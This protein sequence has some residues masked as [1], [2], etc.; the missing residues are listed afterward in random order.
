MYVLGEDRRYHR[1]ARDN[2][3]HL[4]SSLLPGFAL[5]TALLWQTPLP[6]AP[7]IVALAQTMGTN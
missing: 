1:A 6:S 2:E 3:G 7:E 4:I 5:D